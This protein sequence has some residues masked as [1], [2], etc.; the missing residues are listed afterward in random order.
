MASS[1]TSEDTP[2]P[3]KRLRQDPDSH[4]STRK[5]HQNTRL[6]VPFRALG[7]ITDHV[8]FVLQ[9]R[10]Y[11][12]AVDGP[13][14]HL[15]TCLG[16]SWALWEGGKMGLL[17]V[18]PDAPHKIS[19]L[20]MDGDAV[21]AS[22]GPYAIK[23][24]RGKEVLRITNP[25]EAYLS[26]ITIFGTQIMALSEDGRRMFLWDS[27]TGDLNS[28]IEF[29]VGFTATMI[30]H[31]A[32]YVNKVLVSSSQGSIQLWNV[33]SHT[34]IF[35][36]SSSRLV[37]SP[38]TAD[39]STCSITAL[40]QS[41]AIDVVGIGFMSGEISVYDVRADE[42]LMRMFMEGGGVRALGFRADGHPVLASASSSG[43]LALWDLNAGGR[44]L[45]MVR[46][47]HDGAITA[48][49][50]VPG[51]PVLITS[52]EDNSVKQW[53][54]D[55]PTGP[56]RLLKFRTGHQAPPHL[57][58]Y[59]GEDGKQLL[60]ASR[61]RSLRC[62]SVVRDSRSFELSQGTLAKKATSLSIP[63]ASLK[64]P[65]VTSLSYSSARAKDWDDIITGHTDLP[66]ARTW[67]MMN[68]KLGSHTLAFGNP[69]K[70]KAHERAVYGSVQSVCVTTCGNFS[71]V[72][73][74]M[75]QISLWNLQSGIKRKSFDIGLRPSEIS[76]PGKKKEGRAVSG[77][78]TDALNTL[79]IAATTDGTIN[80]FDFH[81]TRLEH[82]LTLPASVLS[83]LLNRDSGLLAIICED[84]V[85]RVVDIETRRVVRELSGF[86][87]KILDIAFSPDS[88]WLVATSLDSIIR[89]FDVPTGRLIDAF[90]TP[91]VATSLTFSPTN[92]FLAT[93]HVDSVGVYLWQVPQ[94]HISFHSILEE[95]IDSVDMPSMQGVAE[96]E[97]LDSLTALTVADTPE[98]P[99]STPP[100]LDGDL[101][102]LTLL[103]RSRWQTL[104]N[105]EVIQQRNK[106]KEPPKAPEQAPFFLPTLPGVETRFEVQQKQVEAK[107]ETRRLYQAAANTNSVFLEKLLAC[108]PT[109][110]CKPFGSQP[111]AVALI[112]SKDEELFA[113]AKTLSP[114]ALDLEL[115]SLVTLEHLQAFIIA[116]T[117]R[118]R[119][120]RDFEAV[121]TFQS[122]FLR[123]NAD[124]IVSNAELQS[125]LDTLSQVQRQESDRVLQL[126]ASSLGTLGFPRLIFALLTP[127]RRLL[128]ATCLI[129]QLRSTGMAAT[130]TRFSIVTLVLFGLSIGF[131][132]FPVYLRLGTKKI[133]INLTTAPILTIAIL[134]ASQCIGS[135]QIRD[136]IVGTSG[137]E[138][139][140]ILILFFCLAYMT[141]TLDISGVFQAAAFWVSNKGGTQGRRLYFYFYAMITLLGIFVGNDAV[142][143]SGTVFLIYY[144]RS[145]DVYPVPWL[146]AEFA[147]ANTASMVLA[148]GNITNVVICEA[149][150]V[151][152]A[153]FTLYT[154]LAFLACSVACYGAL[155]LQFREDRHIPRRMKSVGTLDV[156]TA[157][158]DPVAACVGSFLL[159]SCIVV[160]LV[161]S[162]YKI[163]VWKI[164]LPFAGSKLVFDLVWDY[165]RTAS[166][167]SSEGSTPSGWKYRLSSR[168]PTV[169]A[170][171]PRL[172][173][174]LIPFSFS[175][176]I[177]IEALSH[178][179]W[180]DVFSHWLVAA[181]GRSMH[182]TIWLV[183]V[184]TVLLCNVAGTNI[185]ATILMT[186]VVL[187][188]GLPPHANR[189]AGVALAVASNIG[190]VSFTF[191]ASLA[192]LLWKGILQQKETEI[193]AEEVRREEIDL[194]T[195][196]PSTDKL[197]ESF[198]HCRCSSYADCLNV[199]QGVFAKWNALQL[200]VM[201]VVGL[202]VVS[203]EMAVLYRHSH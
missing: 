174:A 33:L 73:T 46:G 203:A 135:T 91:S 39:S 38:D 27:T 113:F 5:S 110:D 197:T 85:L 160:I 177:L 192:G 16:R 191:S 117:Q 120:R 95:D 11:K 37:S 52:G 179:G 126:I 34:C 41:P 140:N 76:I 101:I 28:T 12:G 98:D 83:I 81:T 157:I 49:E 132:I 2:P 202:G 100:Q 185:G 51:Q 148:V 134:W 121:Q 144:T 112:F 60:T 153:S 64:L 10:S 158:K 30:L 114:A 143:L 151:P 109:S 32:T 48:V 119:S 116:L 173:F 47:A 87:G 43:H 183:G 67:T 96:E 80:F 86:K 165:A 23:Y 17:F 129:E 156:R 142:I 50:W 55:S 106:P 161:V 103:P 136:G 162:F 26:F 115:H 141:I 31:P 107:K 118:L 61:D 105:L 58:R 176:F 82:T 102:T 66:G 13:R 127:R 125:D 8:P 184:L 77:L 56:P 187:Q 193:T 19:C 130:I 122:V 57:I 97:A 40:T 182:A 198:A 63:L 14:I 69:A 94:F 172:P 181:S 45:H 128:D 108:D 53:L 104:L 22:S 147:S 190:A 199:S 186:K 155:A 89:T 111:A 3:R 79:V 188:A 171:L 4:S 9:T 6:F 35:K 159:F 44:L 164:S 71:L 201:T 133:P 78:A 1:T 145:A 25:L 170:A 15:L 189:A 24:L 42:R 70:G 178:Q 196:R 167:D 163:D 59:Y 54:F 138:P 154:I 131:V 139:Y 93:A 65:P 74:S 20:A 150:N 195:G 29:D 124:V 62:T 92:D 68:K 18:G 149:F 194:A 99:F 169:F 21:W 168:F 137:V 36:F 72:S 166:G 152:F 200:L 75:G 123:M 90:R 7:L 180:I 88:R 84:Q 146:M 175:Q